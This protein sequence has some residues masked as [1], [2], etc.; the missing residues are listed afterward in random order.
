MTVNSRNLCV[1]IKGP[2][3]V[4]ICCPFSKI[5][6]LIPCMNKI[7]CLYYRLQTHFSGVHRHSCSWSWIL[8]V[9]KTNWCAPCNSQKEKAREKKK[10]ACRCNRDQY[11]NIDHLFQFFRINCNF[12][13]FKQVAC[14]AFKSILIRSDLRLTV[15]LGKVELIKW[16]Y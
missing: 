16:A 4:A 7:K 14:C 2:N 11:F 8:F 6:S 12:V 10:D 13:S 3:F 9:P 1:S 15:E 5:C